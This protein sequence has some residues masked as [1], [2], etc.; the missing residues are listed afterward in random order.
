MGTRELAPCPQCGCTKVVPVV[1]GLP[2]DELME[3]ARRG[4]VALGGCMPLPGV[5]G[6][7]TECG[8]RR[9]AQEASDADS[10]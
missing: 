1:F 2:G 6:A 10:A 9:S 7:C 5:I 4:E 3:R 8:R